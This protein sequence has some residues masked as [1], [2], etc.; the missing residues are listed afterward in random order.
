MANNKGQHHGWIITTC[1]ALSVFSTL[2]FLILFPDETTMLLIKY[3]FYIVIIILGGV[4][5]I[6]WNNKKRQ[7][8]SQIDL[9]NSDK[10]VKVVEQLI[11]RN[12]FVLESKKTQL[13]DDDKSHDIKEWKDEKYKFA[14]KYVFPVVSEADVPLDVVSD[15][16]EK[17]LRGGAIRGIRPPT[18]SVTSIKN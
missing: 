1:L 13:I 2:Y 9:S 7:N 16:I 12:R 17:S 4:L 15:L 11:W 10:K 14:Q 5:A 3:L 8:T 6:M 18:Y